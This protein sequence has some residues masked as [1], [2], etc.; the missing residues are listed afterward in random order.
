MS[1]SLPNQEYTKLAR[2]Y[3]DN[4]AHLT[5]TDKAHI[6]GLCEIV[7]MLQD[8]NSELEGVQ[9]SALK[10]KLRSA[11]EYMARLETE[12]AALRERQ[13]TADHPL[14]RFLLGEDE[15]EGRWFG[16]CEDRGRYKARY[17]WRSHLRALLK[18]APQQPSPGG[19]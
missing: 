3:A 18:I 1:E 15:Y 19:E 17:W 11:E 14:I 6:R 13:I 4:M 16:D 10:E 8:R 7:E 5:L 2:A 9:P 12:N